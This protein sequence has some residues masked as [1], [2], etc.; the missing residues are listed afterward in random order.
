VELEDVFR[1]H[2]RAVFAY[3]LRVVGN[4]QDA[5]EL[6]QEIFV[7][8]WPRGRGRPRGNRPLN[9]VGGEDARSIA[10]H[11]V[12]LLAHLGDLDSA[13]GLVIGWLCII[14]T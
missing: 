6:T 3:F 5:E 2:Q 8:A 13:M 14:T 12:Q 10:L 4:R 9:P 11:A 1:A 7:R